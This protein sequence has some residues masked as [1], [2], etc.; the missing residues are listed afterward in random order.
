MGG[1]E[2]SGTLVGNENWPCFVYD[3]ILGIWTKVNLH[4]SSSRAGHA[5]LSIAIKKND[6]VLSYC[7]FLSGGEIA[8]T[9]GKE[10]CQR[11]LTNQILVMK[12]NSRFFY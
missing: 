7:F 9:D 4:I 6:G 8:D 3:T 12:S 1:W 11:I 2:K 5:S 10:K